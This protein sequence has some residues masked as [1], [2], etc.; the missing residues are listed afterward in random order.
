MPSS[1]LVCPLGHVT[2][3]N[4]CYSPNPRIKDDDWTGSG[5]RMNWEDAR[6]E[7]RKLSSQ[8]PLLK[9]DFISLHSEE[10]YHFL[11]HN[12]WCSD[13]GINR[14][15]TSW[16]DMAGFW[17][18]LNDRDVEGEYKWSDGAVL[19]YADPITSATSP[20]WRPG[21]PHDIGVSV[22]KIILI[23]VLRDCFI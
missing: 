16:K 4:N 2:F 6:D 7:C 19:D 11:L 5:S 20:P 9:Y 14:S 15:Y 21:E 18:G 12:P 1:I 13:C 17:T 10:E 3:G 22:N 23:L 8:Y